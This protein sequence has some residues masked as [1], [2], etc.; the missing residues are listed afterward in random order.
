[1]GFTALPFVFVFVLMQRP[2]SCFL[3][4]SAGEPSLGKKT[5]IAAAPAP[6]RLQQP[7]GGH[8]VPAGI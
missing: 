3:R 4:S 1:M 7:G 2:A 5:K 8:A 6:R